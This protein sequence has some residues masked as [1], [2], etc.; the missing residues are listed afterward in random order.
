MSHIPG[1]YPATPDEQPVTLSQ[2]LRHPLATLGAGQHESNEHSKLQKAQD[3]RSHKHADSGVGIV[4]ADPTLGGTQ[5]LTESRPTELSADREVSGPSQGTSTSGGLHAIVSEPRPSAQEP[6]LFAN[7]PHITTNEHNT[8]NEP[9]T[10]ASTSSPKDS[11]DHV[12]APLRVSTD[13]QGPVD[14]NHRDSTLNK[15]STVNKDTGAPYWGNLPKAMSG[16]IYNTVMG[17]GSPKEDHAQHQNLPQKSAPSPARVSGDAVDFPKGGVYNTVAGHGS[18]DEET[19]RHNAPTGA[20]SENNQT[21]ALG[22]EPTHQHATSSG[23]AAAALP[24][25]QPL[26]Q[27]PESRG[28]APSA[29]MVSTGMAGMGAPQQAP[30]AARTIDQTQS[31]SPRA[32]PLNSSHQ[33]TRRQS[34]DDAH[35]GQGYIVP[36]AAAGV[37]GAGVAAAHQAD[38]PK[39]LQKPREASPNEEPRRR[40]MGPS[41]D[42]R[43]HP[44]RGLVTHAEGPARSPNRRSAPGSDSSSPVSSERKKHGILGIFHRH[45]DDK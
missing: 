39:K 44:T 1:E 40:S 11:H 45:K 22:R 16:G 18:H 21:G 29:G 36:A 28:T 13:G 43:A 7:D 6:R 35:V 14:D 2:R 5:R 19:M 25:S 37:A 9:H 24:M 30:D 31:T 4:D 32:F 38:K 26:S 8:T 33:D 3:P 34:A 12:A 42:R 15:D 27:H 17:H 20:F 10:T 41:S 23:M